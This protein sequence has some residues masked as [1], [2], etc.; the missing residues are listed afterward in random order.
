LSI[1]NLTVEAETLCLNAISFSDILSLAF[2][3][4]DNLVLFEIKQCLL[5][6]VVD[7]VKVELQ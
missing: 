2:K 4:I 5:T 3:A 1:V 7:N 6:S